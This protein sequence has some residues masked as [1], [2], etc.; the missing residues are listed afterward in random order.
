MIHTGDSRRTPSSHTGSG[1]SKQGP[2]ATA[3]NALNGSGAGF[4]GLAGTAGFAGTAGP[5]RGERGG[6]SFKR[7]C[8]SD[9]ANA[10]A[11]SGA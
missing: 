4:A 11:G 9:T 6:S 3:T 7:N 1:A 2:G 8:R 10:Y 5:A